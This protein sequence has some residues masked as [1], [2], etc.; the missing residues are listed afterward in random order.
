[1]VAIHDVAP[2]WLEELT[3]VL[4][5]LDSFNARPRVL[6]VVPENLRFSS[7]LMRLLRSEQAKGSEIV[8]HGYSHRRSGPWRGPWQRRLRAALFAPRQAEFLT[9][10]P[11]EIESRLL[12]GCEILEL[13]GLR[14]NGFCAPAWIEPAGLH[15]ILR[16]VGFRYDVAM[17]SLL[18]LAT[19]R[20]IWMDW[21]GYMGAGRMQ[22]ALLGVASR[23]NALVQPAFPA[24]KLFLHPQAVRE[25]RAARHII[26]VVPRLMRARSLTTYGG[27]LGE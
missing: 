10:T 6:K 22:E 20:R 21:L 2:E 13:A 16:R 24:V 3:F 5:R 17:T 15:P 25:S 27:L 1:V 23:I 4:R 14:A 9:L 12:R 11:A 19:G 26:D 8:L 7:E 18:D